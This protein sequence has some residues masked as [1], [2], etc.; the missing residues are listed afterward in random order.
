MWH[1]CDG[2]GSAGASHY[3]TTLRGV[4][5]G[6]AR[7]WL[8]VEHR[9]GARFSGCGVSAK[10]FAARCHSTARCSAVPMFCVQ[11]RCGRRNGR[12]VPVREAIRARRRA[13]TYTRRPSGCSELST[14]SVTRRFVATIR[15]AT[16][17]CSEG[18][19]TR[20]GAC[21]RTRSIAC[22][23]WSGPVDVRGRQSV[24]PMARARSSSSAA[25]T[26]QTSTVGR[27]HSG[28]MAS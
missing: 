4:A 22:R 26:D 9:G 27:L 11:R 21:S 12:P 17:C 25:A 15:V 19:Q 5:G 23:S 18:A 24:A 1:S 10:R 2:T 6:T 14:T 20:A 8:F 28:W 7:D 13:S 16:A 3:R